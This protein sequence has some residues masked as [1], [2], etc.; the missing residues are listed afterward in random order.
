MRKVGIV[1]CGV[2]AKKLLI[3]RESYLHFTA[4]FL[5]RVR[6]MCPFKLNLF[7]LIRCGIALYHSKKA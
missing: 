2:I 6:D 7:S 5:R 3:A 1:G 4:S